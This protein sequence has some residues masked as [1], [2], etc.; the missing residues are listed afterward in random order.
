[1]CTFVVFSNS[2]FW[3]VIR[4]SFGTWGVRVSAVWQMWGIC[5]NGAGWVVGQES[6]AMGH[7]RVAY[8]GF[9]RASKVL[10][11]AWLAVTKLPRGLWASSEVKHVET[12]AP[13]LEMGRWRGFVGVWSRL[14]VRCLSHPGGRLSCS[15][16]CP[17]GAAST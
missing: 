13:F 10:P 1:M 12:P 4:S 2:T 15:R 7:G 6:A 14:P 11:V 9:L 3:F 16:R 5:G 8:V 17:L